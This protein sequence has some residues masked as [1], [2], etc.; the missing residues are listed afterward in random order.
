[1][2]D[3]MDIALLTAGSLGDVAPFVALGRGLTAAGHTVRLAA[4]SENEAL[5]TGEGL[6]FASLEVDF[7]A[8]ADPEAVSG[9]TGGSPRAMLQAY[10]ESQDSM[11]TLIH[12]AGRAADGADAIVFH[13]KTFVGGHIA[14]ARG[15]PVFLWAAA[16]V[17][18]PTAEF[19]V[20]VSSKLD[21]GPLNRL[22]YKA[23]LGTAM[24]Y[25]SMINEWRADA[26]GLPATG[27]FA[28]P[29]SVAG[30][31][32]PVLYAFSETVVA[33]PADWPERVHVTGYWFL[34]SDP[35]DGL[36]A[37][38]SAFLE[39]GEAPVYIG[40]GSLA[41]RDPG[42]T[43]DVVLEAVAEAGVR[44][45]IATGW[46][47]LTADDVP[48]NVHLVDG[49]PHDRLFPRCAAVVHHGGSG[50]TAAGLRAGV[51]SVICPFFGDQP[52]WGA[53]VAAIGA[54]PEPIPQKQLTSER[55]ARAL[56]LA[57]AD[58]GL[59]ARTEAIAETLEAEDGVGATI[60][61]IEAA[62]RS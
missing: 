57:L 34:D 8:M 44:A 19:A 41:G 46:G 6:E 18:V 17:L 20:P 22:S 10:R 30:H 53:R 47:G 23:S 56:E 48:A 36:D 33:P 49:A 38:L 9:A 59:R 2:L 16:P 15:I 27:R 54:G 32:L 12:A 43:T 25:R 62:A 51:P 1:M 7:R 13:P 11:R 45:V 31:A 50:T 3:I 14:E 29:F 24:P 39:D 21:L 52:F 28:D 58:P 37:E 40:F 42:R 35:D 61:L 60:E 5:V 55:L 26:L 4:P